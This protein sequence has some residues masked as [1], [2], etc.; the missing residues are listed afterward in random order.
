M[1]SRRHEVA[2]LP[3]DFEATSRE[4]FESMRTLHISRIAEMPR[5]ELYLD[6]VLSIIGT[7]LEFIYLPGERIVTGAMVNNYVKQRLAPQPVRKRYTRR[8]LATLL[9]VCAFKR[10]LSIAQIAQ[11]FEMARAAN[12]DVERA[13]DDI[14]TCLEQT[15]RALFVGGRA[16]FLLADVPHLS[17]VDSDGNRCPSELEALLD[18]AVL[19]LACKVYADRMLA[20]EAMRPEMPELT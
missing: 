17:L 11:L 8:H 3:A 18:N 15:I 13:Y 14:A 2:E 12:L 7:E 5:I 19:L 1:A 9:F 20:L 16:E 4:L 10:V 6:Q